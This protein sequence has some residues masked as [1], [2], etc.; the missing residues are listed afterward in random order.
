VFEACYPQEQRMAKDPRR[1]AEELAQG[2]LLDDP[3][4]LKETVDRVLQGLLEAEMTEHVGAAPYGRTTERK[5]LRNGHKMR[6]LST[7]G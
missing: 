6:T 1:L 5:G 3:S 4:F 7:R 2:V